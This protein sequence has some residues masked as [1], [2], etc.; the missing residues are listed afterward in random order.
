MISIAKDIASGEGIPGLHTPIKAARC[1][2]LAIRRP[3]N[4]KNSILLIMGMY[5]LPAKSLPYLY[6]TVAIVSSRGDVPAIGRPGDASHKT[7]M[8]V[9][10]DNTSA[11]ES[12]PHLYNTSGIARSN[13]FAIRGPCYR[14]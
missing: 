6:C 8:A 2:T 10:G 11:S 1:N 5:M 14:K 12:L 7:G 3:R 13:V 9:I 4:G